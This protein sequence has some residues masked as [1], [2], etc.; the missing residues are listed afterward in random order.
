[1]LENQVK[2]AKEELAKRRYK[3]GVVKGP[4]VENQVAIYQ[5]PEEEDAAPKRNSMAPA[6]HP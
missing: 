2:K 5:P 6:R 1:M 4:Q 3:L